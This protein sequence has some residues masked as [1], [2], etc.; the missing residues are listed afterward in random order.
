MV[1]PVSG[2]AV[3]FGIGYGLL[4]D[5]GFRYCGNSIS[6]SRKMNSKNMHTRGGA[7]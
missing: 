3:I 2:S 4:I 1:T 6:F 7:F 5:K